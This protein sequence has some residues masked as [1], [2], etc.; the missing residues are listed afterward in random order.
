MADEPVAGQAGDLLQ[1]AG[2]PEEVGRPGDDLEAGL[3]GELGHRLPV[4]LDDERVASAD[5]QQR[6]LAHGAEVPAGEVGPAAA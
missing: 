5:D 2:F 3:T 6:G 1:G 4:E